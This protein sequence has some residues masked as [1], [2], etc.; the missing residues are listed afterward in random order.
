MLLRIEEELAMVRRMLKFIRLKEM[1]KIAVVAASK[2]KEMK[3]T[4]SI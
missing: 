1:S 2:R 4:C 3:I